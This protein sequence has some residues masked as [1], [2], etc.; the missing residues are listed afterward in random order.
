GRV[1]ATGGGAAVFAAFASAVLV[2][3]VA[4]PYFTLGKKWGFAVPLLASAGVITAVG[5]VDDIR[6]LRGRHKLIGQLLACSVL[7]ASGL[8]VR[9]VSAFGVSVD[10]GIMAV[11]FTIFWLLGAINSVNLLDGLD[12]FAST[13]GVILA[14]AVG[15]MAAVDGRTEL[16]LMAFAFAGALVGFLRFNFPPA[17]IFLGDAGSMLIGLVVGAI[18]VEAS[19]KGPGTALLAAPAAIWLIPIADTGCAI[20][21]RKLT[22]QSIYS[23]D[24]GHFH[25]RLLDR[26][27]C[28][29]RVLV[30]VAVACLATATGALLSVVFQTDLIAVLTAAG[31][32]L[33]LVTT[34]IFGRA[35]ARLVARRVRSL[36][37]IKEVSSNGESTQHNNTVHLQGELPWSDLWEEILDDI[38]AVELGFQS[39]IL[40]INVPRMHESFHGEWK[41][42]TN[43]ASSDSERA[44]LWQLCVPL[45]LD[46]DEIGIF[47]VSGKRKGLPTELFYELLRELSERLECHVA[48][49]CERHFL[50][51]TASGELASAPTDPTNGLA[52]GTLRPAPK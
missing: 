19:L 7:I 3:W 25:H 35:E 12:G 18:S 16:A 50:S 45:S 2:T 32:L 14:G 48:D 17:T 1:V 36:A 11:P 27:G 51:K 40:T 41:S 22:G 49:F 43:S 4:S 37:G 33:I 5:L 34:D 42:A 20:V 8:V 26:L 52:G 28:N 24:H 6:P 39:L 21:R 31:I 47:Q 30:F 10:L 13:I 38:E 15:C 29:K 9:N 44:Q 23:V 46:G